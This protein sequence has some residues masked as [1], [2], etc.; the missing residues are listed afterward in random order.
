MVSPGF[1]NPFLGIQLGGVEKWPGVLE[2][3]ANETVGGDIGRRL[4]VKVPTEILEVRELLGRGSR[5]LSSTACLVFSEN[6]KGNQKT[7]LSCLYE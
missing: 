7:K 6:K 5:E 2:A 4:C 3:A 1:I